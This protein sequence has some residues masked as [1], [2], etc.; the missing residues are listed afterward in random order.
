MSIQSSA[1]LSHHR[2]TK[3][4]LLAAPVLLLLA[5]ATPASAHH[6]LNGAT[7]SN[8]F[9]G[10]MSGLA[11]PIIGVDHFAFV[12]AAGLLA[13]SYRQGWMSL[14]A[15][16]LAAMLGTG[17]H[18]AEVDI[19]GVEFLISGSIL[20]FGILLARKQLLGNGVIVALAA[21][22]GI[23]HG[24]AY[25]E[26]IVGA[27]MTPLAA[28]LAGFTITQLV[29]AF[30]AFGLG[31]VV[32]AQRSTETTAIVPRLQTAGWVIVGIGLTFLSSQLISLA[33]P[34]VGA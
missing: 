6:P 26:A 15:F 31:R 20:L 33:L 34:T 32:I 30:A 5:A 24:Y 9:E 23:F 14:V 10:L 1:S 12:V 27:G 16:V 11:H 8:L 13:A 7:P 29:I 19:P 2:F 4:S 21:I 17:L 28:Y 22:A 3:L 25:G 18:V